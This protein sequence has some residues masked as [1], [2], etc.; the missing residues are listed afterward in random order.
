MGKSSLNKEV[1]KKRQRHG[2]DQQGR[3]RKLSSVVKKRLTEVNERKIEY[4]LSAGS[5]KTKITTEEELGTGAAVF[6]CTPPL[7][8]SAPPFIA[9]VGLNQRRIT[10][11]PLHRHVRGHAE[12]HAEAYGV[13]EGSAAGH[14][15]H[16]PLLLCEYPN[17]PSPVPLHHSI[18]L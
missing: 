11:A 6:H 3:L 13:L 2:T 14:P 9:A 1:R 8:S 4:L 12:R 15:C 18:T 16:G 17:S 10:G 7:S 5:H